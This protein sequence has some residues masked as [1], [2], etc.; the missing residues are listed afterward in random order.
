[1]PNVMTPRGLI[2]YPVLFEDGKLNALSGKK[3]YSVD[4]LFP[5]NTDL[6]VIKEEINKAIEAKWGSKPPKGL[7]NP[8]KD[9]DGTKQNG[10]P[11]KSE[12]KGHYFITLK[13]T[14]RPGVMA[15]DAVTPI[16]D[17]SEVYSGCEGRAIFRAFAYD[18]PANKGVSLSLIHFQKTKDGEPIAGRAVEIEGAFDAIDSEEADNPAN[19]EEA[20][21]S[22]K[23][24]ILRG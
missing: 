8:I 6:S 5:K 12:Y 10:E 11:Y 19:Y 4:I 2:N 13:N 22:K 21:P 15:P 20:K 17:P 7:R 14:R 1:M 3:E 24:S 16:T 23:T 18:Q 9:G